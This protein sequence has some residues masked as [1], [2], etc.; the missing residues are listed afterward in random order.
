MSTL[1]RLAGALVLL[2]AIAGFGGGMGNLVA[3]QQITACL[4]STQACQ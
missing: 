3:D 1:N 2:V 4:R